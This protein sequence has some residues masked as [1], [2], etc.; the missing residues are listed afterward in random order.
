MQK[1]PGLLAQLK[2]GLQGRT[3]KGRDVRIRQLLR[4]AGTRSGEHDLDQARVFHRVHCQKISQVVEKETWIDPVFR[5]GRR[6]I[7]L[8]R[9]GE[10][11][12]EKVPHRGHEVADP[13]TDLPERGRVAPDKVLV[14]LQP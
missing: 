11:L 5:L 9:R 14:R 12:G 6:G 3:D 1:L 8:R 13:G 2:A 7:F 4:Q 10:E